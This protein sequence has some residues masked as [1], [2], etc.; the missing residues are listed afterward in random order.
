MHMCRCLPA[1][2]HSSS[3]VWCTKEKPFLAS[4]PAL[5]SF[6]PD[7]FG[8]NSQVLLPIQSPGEGTSSMW[9]CYSLWSR[10][11]SLLGATVSKL[12]S[13]NRR[14]W[15]KMLIEAWSLIALNWKPPRCPP[16]V[17]WINT[18]VGLCCEIQQNG[19]VNG[20]GTQHSRWNVKNSMWIKE[21]PTEGSHL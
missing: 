17:G 21:G 2:W 3:D 1:C 11:H 6:S 9:C 16:T 12:T 7:G 4:L 20:W 15:T 10:P 18:L 19:G 5:P 13:Y 14:V 8:E